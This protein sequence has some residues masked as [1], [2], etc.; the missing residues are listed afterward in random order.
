MKNNLSQ[1]AKV[2]IFLAILFLHFQILPFYV[3]DYILGGALLVFGIYGRATQSEKEKYEKVASVL[4][5]MLGA[6]LIFYGFDNN[7]N[8]V[9]NSIVHISLLVVVLLLAVAWITVSLIFKG[10]K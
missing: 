10:R 1:S 9:A 2:A 7:F 5:L 8:I 6:I 3:R 4:A